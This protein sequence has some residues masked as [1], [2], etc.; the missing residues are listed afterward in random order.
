MLSE[1]ILITESRPCCDISFSIHKLSLYHFAQGKTPTSTNTYEIIGCQCPHALGHIL[2][3]D[4]LDSMALYQ[5]CLNLTSMQDLLNKT[6]NMNKFES[7]NHPPLP[8]IH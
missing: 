1:N 4:R 5:Q 2:H 3:W 7:S 6:E 8:K